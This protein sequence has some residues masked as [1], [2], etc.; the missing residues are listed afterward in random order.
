M[1]NNKNE[2]LDNI[3]TRRSTRKF[4]QESLP[5]EI[6]EDILTAARFA[7][8]GHNRQSWRFLVIKNQNTLN[9]LNE[10]VKSALL[11]IKKG[12]DEYAQLFGLIRNAEKEKYCFFYGAPVLVVAVNDACNGNALADCACALENMFL[13]ANSLGVGSCYINQLKTL[14][15]K[16]E[17]RD[18]LEQLGLEGDF[19]VCGSAAL[20]YP[21]GESAAL[22]RKSGTVIFAD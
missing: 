10:L 16:R 14:G 2:V 1:M 17:I 3:L 18:F 6:L 19:V 11:D 12:S 21:D 7:P 13:A 4:K 20:G 5:D 9:R 15:N 22:M 8:S